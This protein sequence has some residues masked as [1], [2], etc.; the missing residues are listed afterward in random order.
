MGNSVLWV[1]QL[2]AEHAKPEVMGLSADGPKAHVFC[3]KNCVTY[4]FRMGSSFWGSDGKWFACQ[5]VWAR[6][7]A[8]KGLSQYIKKLLFFNLN[9]VL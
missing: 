9:L 2:G 7:A 1:E 3:V 8:R 4:D 5:M 6:V